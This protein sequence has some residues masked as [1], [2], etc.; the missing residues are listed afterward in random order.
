MPRA[1]PRCACFH[2]TPCHQPLQT[3]P[4]SA[5]EKTEAEGACQPPVFWG[6]QNPGKKRPLFFCLQ[7]AGSPHVGSAVV[8]HQFSYSAARG[9][10]QDRGLNPS[11]LRWQVGILTHC[12][13]R[14]VPQCA[15]FIS[16]L[17]L[18]P[19][20]PEVLVCGPEAGD[21][22]IRRTASSSLMSPP[23]TPA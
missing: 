17:M 14:E 13:T 15:L 2:W 4:H 7:S 8:V 18:L 10:F 6:G 11:C 22:L 9:I 19:S 23:L 20:Q 3:L 12:A 1:H 5:D 16:N 21:P